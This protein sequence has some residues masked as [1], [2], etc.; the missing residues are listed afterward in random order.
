MASRGIGSVFP[1]DFNTIQIKRNKKTSS[2]AYTTKVRRGVVKISFNPKKHKSHNADRRIGKLAQTFSHE[3]F[4]HARRDLT[5]HSQDVPTDTADND[6]RR[7]H[8][9]MHR[10]SFLQA[11]RGTFNA[12]ENSTQKQAFAE[13]F[14]KDVINELS[15]LGLSKHEKTERKQWARARRDS[16]IDAITNPQDHDWT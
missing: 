3:M 13:S 14:S 2:H 12:L 8:S 11:S 6:H 4:V 9:A 16:M 5:A 7:M 10:D 15:G 1:S